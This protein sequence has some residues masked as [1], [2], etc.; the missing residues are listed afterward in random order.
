MERLTFDGDFCDIALCSE[1]RGGSFCE[2]GSCSQ[3]KVWE[4]LKEYEDTGL[5]PGEVVE[6]EKDWITQ[7]TII[8]ECG[9]L[10]RVI[11]MAEADKAGRVVVLPCKVGDTVYVID[12]GDYEHDHRPFVREKTVYEITCKQNK[13]GRYLDWGVCLGHGDCGTIARYRFDK[14]GHSWFLTRAEAEKD[15][16]VNRGKR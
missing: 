14:L 2:D 1:V 9:G 8:G 10:D 13:Y 15:L 7:C 4:R 16:E 3:R 11:E 6:L 5:S 12:K